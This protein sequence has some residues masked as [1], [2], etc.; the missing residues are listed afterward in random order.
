MLN[1]VYPVHDPL[2]LIRWQ[3]QQVQLRAQGCLPL[4]L[5]VALS[6]VHSQLYDLAVQA[7]DALGDVVAAALQGT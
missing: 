1:E 2:P 4:R 6:P 5:H 7:L 3:L